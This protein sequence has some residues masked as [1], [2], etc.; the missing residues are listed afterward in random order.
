M[1]VVVGRL[2]TVGGKSL[3]YFQKLSLAFNLEYLSQFF[4]KFKDQGQFWN[5]L[6]MRILKLSLILEI[7]E[8]MTALFKGKGNGTSSVA[9]KWQH[10][11]LYKVICI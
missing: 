10:I 6:V 4:I 8:E 11:Q 1:V 7:D 3:L 5:L 9:K 2:W